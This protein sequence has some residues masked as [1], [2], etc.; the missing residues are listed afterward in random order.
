MTMLT[1]LTSGIAIVLVS[2]CGGSSV[3]VVE[4]P[5]PSALTFS[6]IADYAEDINDGYN[7]VDITPKNLVPTAGAALYS[8]P[9]GGEMEVGRRVTDV[10]GLMDLEVDFTRDRV[11]GRLG[12]FVTRAGDPIDGTL[13]VRNGDLNRRSN[14]QQVAIFADVDG[15]LRSAAG[16]RIEVDARLLNSGF[17]GRNVDYVGGDIEGDIWVDGQRGSIDLDLQLER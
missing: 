2:A 15:T 16:E 4:G 14:S 8:G 6:E 9:V 10:A 13:S 1:K 12:N 5:S 11:D 3:P 17:K 7:A